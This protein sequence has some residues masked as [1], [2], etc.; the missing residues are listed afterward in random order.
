M[1]AVFCFYKI[2]VPAGVLLWV[3]ATFVGWGATIIFYHLIG[4]SLLFFCGRQKKRNK[5]KGD[6]IFDPSG[7]MGK[8][9]RCGCVGMLLCIA[10]VL[11]LCGMAIWLWWL[12]CALDFC[13][14]A[15]SS[16][17]DKKGANYGLGCGW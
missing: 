17:R 14:A 2:S 12:C 6:P 4:A 9:L 5:R 7:E 13:F 15:G 1:V 16:G 11:S 3:G 8:A 10:L